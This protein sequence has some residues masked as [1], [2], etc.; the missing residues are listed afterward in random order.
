MLEGWWIAIALGILLLVAINAPIFLGACYE[1]SVSSRKDPWLRCTQVLDTVGGAPSSVILLHGFGGTPRDLRT[2]AERLAER[3]FRAIVPVVPDQTGTTFAYGRGRI[4]PGEYAAWLLDLIR[5]ETAAGGRPPSLVGFSMGGALATL[6]AVDHPVA[7]LVLI[8]PYFNLPERIQW[9]AGV[10]SWLRWIVPVVPKVAKGQ[11]LDPD[12]YRE[13]ATGSY[14]ISLRAAQRLAQLTRIARDKAPHLTVPTLVL[15]SSKDN[16][17][18]FA[19]TERLFRG[20]DNARLV[21]CDQSDHIVTYD[22]D[23]EL[24]LMEALSFLVSPMPP[25]RA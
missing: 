2:L 20:L 13:Y 4:S 21:A 5:S 7:R 17:A 18:S 25:G 15:A 3:G 9:V 1:W 12:G 23:R 16:V 19:T 8:S 14:F 10:S 11:I 6:A 24:V 22:Y